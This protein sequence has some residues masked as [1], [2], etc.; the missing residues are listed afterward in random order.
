MISKISGVIDS[1]DTNSVTVMIGGFGVRV[2]A[3]SRTLQTLGAPGEAATLLTEL[4]VREDSLTLFGFKSES[5][6][7]WFRLLTSVQGVGAKSGLSILSVCPPEKLQMAIAAQDKAPLTQADGV[8]PKLALRIVTELKDKAASALTADF[9]PHQASKSDGG[10]AET[11]QAMPLQ[12][13]VSA[14]VNLG[15]G[16]TEAHAAVLRVNPELVANGNIS[17]LIRLALKE[18][19]N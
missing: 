13:A 8:G 12:D 18:L 9:V 3:S 7:N 15:Y 19:A 6:L 11:Q 2:Y 1:F 16:R 17:D 14:L 10:K 5:E 4:Q